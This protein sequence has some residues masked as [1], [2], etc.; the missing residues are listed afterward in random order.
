MNNPGGEYMGACYSIEEALQFRDKYY[1]QPTSTIPRPAILDLKK[2]NPHITEG[3]KYPLPERLI[4]TKKSD[5]GKGRIYKKGIASYHIYH[6]GNS[7]SKSYYCACRTYEQA[8]YTRK[9][10]QECDWDRTQLPRIQEEY[11][12][13][14][15]W[16][17]N[18]YKYINVD[19][20]FKKR[21]G[22]TQYFINIPRA[23]L[24]DNRQLEHL[25]GYSHVEDA[26]YERDW[27]MN[28]EWDYEALVYTI[29]DRE[30]PYY[31][32]E[33]PPYPERKILNLR[34][35]DF[36][37]K[38]LT[39]IFHLIYDKGITHQEEIMNRMGIKSSVT[40]RNWL[41]KFWNSSWEEFKQI[42]LTG[43]NPINVLEKNE[44]I[45][46]PDLSKTMPSN[47]NGWVQKSSI[48]KNPY[49][50]RKGNVEYGYYPT[51]AMARKVVKKLVECNWD[52]NRLPEIKKSVGYVERPKRGNVY[53]A[54][55]GW[56]IRR[57]NKSRKMVNY[58]YYK[59]KRIADLTRDFLKENDWSKEIY[60]KLRE[61]AEYIIGLLD[62]IPYNMFHAN[63]NTIREHNLE[64][65]ETYFNN[66]YY[67]Y[68]RGK[69]QV[70]KMIDGEIK[71]FGRYDTEKEA[72]EVVEIL[73]LNNWDGTVLTELKGV[74]L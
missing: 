51:E 63:R 19:N 46:Q 71:Q 33:I 7:K 2:D 47:F 20:Q 67:S 43:E 23:Y 10:L 58:G 4:P 66:K 48:K 34:E 18:F 61:E 27:L 49:M 60:P 52:K 45:Y 14:Y 32:M 12:L 15:T 62:T 21:T 37:E 13:W 16:L 11:P 26:L 59:D 68:N 44:I 31:D 54:G 35:R 6:G 36:H 24:S 9:R 70:T 17:M 39:E 40:L 22:R 5:Y 56:C 42:S 28:N 64:I 55:K 69:Y 3:L 73:R 30:N 1:G 65:M 72:Q 8:Y 38:E 50:V 29:D 74:I 53:K 57:K 25:L 41:N